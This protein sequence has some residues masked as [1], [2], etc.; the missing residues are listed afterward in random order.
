MMLSLFWNDSLPS[1]VHMSFLVRYLFTFFAC[2]F[3]WVVH[4][5][6]VE[7]SDLFVYFGVI[8][9][10]SIRYFFCS[11]FLPICVAGV[12]FSWI[13]NFI[14]YFDTILF[15]TCVNSILLGIF[16][17]D[18]TPSIKIIVIFNHFLPS[19]FLILNSYLYCISL[20]NK[21]YPALSF[22]CHF[23]LLL[24]LLNYM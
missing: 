11:Y 15:G 17:I 18:F 24:S 7:F 14:M 2:V 23:V 9:I 19:T 5:P 8:T 3:N 4:F 13:V 1:V 20:F 12:S 16:I 6:I 10:L 21:L 22:R